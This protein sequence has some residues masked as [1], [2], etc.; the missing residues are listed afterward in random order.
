MDRLSSERASTCNHMSPIYWSTGGNFLAAPE[1][2][3]INIMNIRGKFDFFSSSS[4]LTSSYLWKKLLTIEKSIFFI[5]VVFFFFLFG[6]YLW[7]KVT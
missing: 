7:P 1:N 3:H 4:S 2:K 6:T 5:A